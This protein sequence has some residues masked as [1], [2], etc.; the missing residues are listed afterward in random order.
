MYRPRVPSLR[1]LAL[2]ITAAA[3]AAVAGACGGASF[4]AETADTADSDQTSALGVPPGPAR[5]AADTPD[6][7]APQPGKPPPKPLERQYTGLAS[8]AR[9]DREIYTIMGGVTHFLGVKCTYCHLVPDYRAMT[10]RKHIANWMARELI[11]RLAKKSAGPNGE[12]GEVWCNDCHVVN[13]KATPKI[14][15]NPRDERWAIEWMTTHMVENFQTAKGNALYCKSCHQGT[16]GSPQF[17]RKIILSDR[18]PR[19]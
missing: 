17:Q 8:K 11:P 10:H 13:G 7:C 15:G 4:P 19:D 2:A 5:R 3:W 18:L 16:L 9:C 12:A 1:W 14:L 6:D